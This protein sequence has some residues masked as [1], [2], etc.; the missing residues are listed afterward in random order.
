MDQESPIT[1]HLLLPRPHAIICRVAH[2][3]RIAADLVPPAA[4]APLRTVSM[5]RPRTAIGTAASLVLVLASSAACAPRATTSAGDAAAPAA[6][7]AQ[8]AAV[9]SAT[10][11]RYVPPRMIRGG[12]A[13]PVR[14]VSPE[15]RSASMP[16][17]PPRIDVSYEVMIDTAGNAKVETLIVRGTQADAFRE[18]LLVSLRTARFAPATRDGVPVEGWYRTRIQTRR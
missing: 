13:P 2:G 8:G 9:D 17:T 16:S 11:G 5:I 12:Q 15:R 6:V 7:Q 1:P 3:L 18:S 10:T 4:L 14:V